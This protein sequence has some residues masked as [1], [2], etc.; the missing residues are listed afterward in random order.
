MRRLFEKRTVEEGI[1]SIGWAFGYVTGDYRSLVSKARASGINARNV[2]AKESGKYHKKGKT[3]LRLCGDPYRVEQFF[4]EN[5][6]RV[7]MNGGGPCPE[8]PVEGEA[9]L[10]RYS[11]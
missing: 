8:N 1:Y 3:V 11:R 7:F 9:S 10:K 4:M 2:K 5:G 6:F